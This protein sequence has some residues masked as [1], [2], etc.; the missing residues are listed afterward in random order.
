MSLTRREFCIVAGTA[1]TAG[2]AN[3]A[4]NDFG[5]LNLVNDGRLTVRPR[6]PKQAAGPGKNSLF[7]DRDRDAILQIPKQ[8][9][10]G[11]VPLLVMLHG[12]TQSADD[13]FDYLGSTPEDAGVA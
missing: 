4:C 6:T 1:F 13:M 2:V 10:K 11:P 9:V 3:L 5:P 12:A 7:L 8:S